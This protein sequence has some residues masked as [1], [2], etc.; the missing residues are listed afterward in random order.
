M[1]EIMRVKDE[2]E[3]GKNKDKKK[4]RGDASYNESVRAK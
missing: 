2:R 3:R 1:S 4:Q